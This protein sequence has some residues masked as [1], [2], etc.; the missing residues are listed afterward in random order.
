MKRLTL[1]IYDDALWNEIKRH[2]A[3]SGKV[4]NDALCDLLRA[5]L[6]IQAQRENALLDRLEAI[7][8][9]VQQVDVTASPNVDT[10]G[11][12]DMLNAFMMGERA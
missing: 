3:Q 4:Q 1:R 11:L 8:Q 10:S 7:L 9:G 12:D 5:G 2:V 6:G